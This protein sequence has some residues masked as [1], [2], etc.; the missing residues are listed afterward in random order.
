M[1]RNVS[2]SGWMG[3]QTS[4]WNDGFLTFP[5]VATINGTPE[6]PFSPCSALVFTDERDDSIDDGYFAI[7]MVSDDIANVPGTYHGNAGGVTFADGH[8]EMH[9]WTT[10]NVLARQ[11][12]G[13][14]TGDGANGGRL[15][16][17]PALPNN[18]DMLWIRA[19]ATVPSN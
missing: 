9:A 2:M 12:A 8:A 10:T 18:P 5:K 15:G 11:I 17:V 4:V 6:H 19:H 1:V 13:V 14:D 16:F 3:Y 7:E